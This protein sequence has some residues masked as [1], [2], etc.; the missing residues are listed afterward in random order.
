MK[1]MRQKKVCNMIR[2][3]L[4]HQEMVDMHTATEDIKNFVGGAELPVSVLDNTIEVGQDENGDPITKTWREHLYHKVSVDGTMVFM[5]AAEPIRWKDGKCVA[6]SNANKTMFLK[7][8]DLFGIDNM[9]TKSERNV[10]LN[11]EAY[12]LPSEI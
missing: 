4:T 11:S 7:Y 10:L 12:R 9:I 1:D 2:P 3:S 6:C 8:A 5:E